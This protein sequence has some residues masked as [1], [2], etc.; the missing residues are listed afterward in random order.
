MLAFSEILK[1]QF[2]KGKKIKNIRHQIIE[3]LLDIVLIIISVYIALFVESWAER[4][5]DN[6]RLHQYYK[7]FES[8]VQKDIEDLKFVY[9]DAEKHIATYKTHV[10]FIKQGGPRDS[11]LRYLGKLANA[12]LFLNSNMLSYKSMMASGDIRLI[13]NLKVREALLSLEMTYEGLKVQEEIYLEFVKNTLTKYLSD[14]FDLLNGKPL[15]PEF[16]KLPSYANIVVMSNG[17]NESRLDRY[18]E[19]VAKAQKTLEIIKQEIE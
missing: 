10:R 18:K 5:H 6:E 11:L 14:N 12:N 13:E 16:F 8:E 15:N 4:Q 17:L 2:H 1:S 7:N 3:K 19:A 9:A